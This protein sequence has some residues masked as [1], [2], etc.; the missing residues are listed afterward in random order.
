MVL[1]SVPIWSGATSP[2]ASRS[3]THTA[4]QPATETMRPTRCALG[5]NPSEPSMFLFLRCRKRRGDAGKVSARRLGD[6][7][8]GFRCGGC[9]S[10]DQPPAWKRDGDDRAHAHL[11]LELH[12]AAVHGDEGIDEREPEARARPLA[13]HRVADALA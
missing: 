4:W 2:R 10:V 13:R 1:T 8:F 7:D 11:A 6:A 12:R 3:S 5:F 9:V